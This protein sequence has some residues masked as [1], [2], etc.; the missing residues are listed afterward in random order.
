MNKWRQIG[1]GTTAKTTVQ[2]K[3]E[4]EKALPEQSLGLQ[5]QAMDK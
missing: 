5:I 1:Q 4:G 2:K 3:C